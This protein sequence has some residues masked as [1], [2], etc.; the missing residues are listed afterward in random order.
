MA[1]NMIPADKIRDIIKKYGQSRAF[2]EVIH[3]L[4]SLAEPANP[5]TGLLGR[6]AQ[7]SSGD[8][9]VCRDDAPNEN[10]MIWVTYVNINLLE[11]KPSELI[12]IWNLTFM[13]HDTK[14]LA[15]IEV[16]RALDAEEA[17]G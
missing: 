3:D 12:P 7:D 10:G 17:V 5:A 4:H 14:P 11:G 6:W 8:D 13:E 2:D 15:V 9:V 16:Q 1:D